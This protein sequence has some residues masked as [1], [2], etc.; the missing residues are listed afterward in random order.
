MLSAFDIWLHNEYPKKLT[1]QGQLEEL[2]QYDEKYGMG[3]L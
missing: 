3:I 2:S 1:D